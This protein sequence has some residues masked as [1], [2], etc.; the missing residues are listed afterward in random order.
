MRIY[1]TSLLAITLLFAGTTA[2]A[3]PRASADAR[4]TGP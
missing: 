2:R 4:V 1:P 3:Q